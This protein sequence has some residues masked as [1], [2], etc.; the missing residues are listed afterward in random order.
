MDVSKIITYSFSFFIKYDNNLWIELLLYAYFI[1]YLNIKSMF[2][3]AYLKISGLKYFHIWIPKVKFFNAN[4]YFFAF[5][6]NFPNF[7]N[8]N[9]FITDI[10]NY[11]IFL[12]VK[13][14]FIIFFYI[15]FKI[16]LAYLIVDE[17]V[18]IILEFT[19]VSAKHIKAITNKSG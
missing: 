17:A 4:S 2:S 6:W 5:I 3:N 13:S 7:V 16:S 1:F 18:K 14:I 11:L 19:F 8:N 12:F 9:C 10:G 15:S